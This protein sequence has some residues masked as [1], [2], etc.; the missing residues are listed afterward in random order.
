MTEILPAEGWYKD[1]YH[2]HDERWFSSGEPTGLVRDGQ[3]ESNDPPPD[4][5]FTGEL[6]RP[7]SPSPPPGAGL[8]RADDAERGTPVDPDAAL[9]EE[10]DTVAFWKP[11]P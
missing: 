1:P 3:V 7:E 9:E 11:M 6:V 8:R 5:R 2:I 10:L 4:E